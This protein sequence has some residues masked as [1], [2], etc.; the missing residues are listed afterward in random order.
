VLDLG[1][2][3]ERVYLAISAISQRFFVTLSEI[4]ST[5]RP[6]NGYDFF[7]ANERSVIGCVLQ[8]GNECA[9]RSFSQDQ[10]TRR[11]YVRQFA[12]LENVPGDLVVN[13]GSW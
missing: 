10:Q 1:N 4:A 3:G 13:L 7:S 6:E 12:R 8:P 2:T 5:G 9:L 11:Q